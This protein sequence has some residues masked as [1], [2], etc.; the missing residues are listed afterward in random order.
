MT[1]TEQ[2]TDTSRMLLTLQAVRAE[3]GNS[4]YVLRC[5]LDTT[6]ARLIGCNDAHILRGIKRTGHWLAREP[7]I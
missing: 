6:I 1:S 2:A 4:D 7:R 3:V 5:M